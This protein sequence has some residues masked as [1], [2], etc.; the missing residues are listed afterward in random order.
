MPPTWKEMYSEYFSEGLDQWND[1]AIRILVEVAY[2][3]ITRQCVSEG[4][5]MVAREELRTIIGCGEAIWFAVLG[6]LEL[7][8]DN[9]T[10]GTQEIRHEGNAIPAVFVHYNGQPGVDRWWAA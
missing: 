2:A 4:V 3:E 8:D 6:C 7:W 10:I 5:Y 9:L 1:P